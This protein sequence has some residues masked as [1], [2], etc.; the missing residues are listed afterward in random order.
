MAR[1]LRVA[2]EYINHVRAALTRNGFVSQAAFM[3]NSQLG[4]SRDTFSKFFNGKPIERIYFEDICLKLGLDWHEIT[5]SSLVKTRQDWGTAPEVRDQDFVGRKNEL[6]QLET[7]ILGDRCR[8]VTILGMGGI[9]KTNISVKLGKGGIGK[10]DLAIKLARNIQDGFDCIIWKSLE[11]APLL[12]DILHDLIKFISK[13]QD[14]TNA[15]TNYQESEKSTV[16][17]QIDLLIDYLKKYRCLLILDN[18]E[19]L[20]E[21]NGRYR[22]EYECYAQLLDKVA[23]VQ[24]QSCVLITSREKLRHLERFAGQDRLVRF[25]HLSGLNYEDGRRIFSAKGNFLGNEQ[26]WCALIDFYNGN[27]FALELAADHILSLF[28]GDIEKFWQYGKPI[29]EDI[30]DLLS[31]HFQ[32]LLER[33]QELVIWLAI[34]REPISIAEIRECIFVNINRDKVANTLRSLQRKFPVEETGNQKFSLHPLLIEYIT[35]YLIPCFLHWE[36]AL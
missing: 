6:E 19:S 29:F 36:F 22:P 27:P 34:C 4:Y 28:G 31:W 7:W 2:Q 11:N 10:T 18:A 35:D 24:H 33:E 23:E 3:E 9:G 16:F 5:Y 13:Q 25:F 15:R 14:I 8:L 32:R 17:K 12:D 21:K 30:D 1:S 20:L 26:Q